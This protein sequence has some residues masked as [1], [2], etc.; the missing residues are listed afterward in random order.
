[1]TNDTLE[2]ISGTAVWALRDSTGNIIKDGRDAVTVPALSA[3]WLEEMDFHKTDVEH[4]YMSY[5]FEV[6][7]QVLSEGTVLFTAPKHFLFRNPNLRYEI[8]GDEI[9]IYADAYAR[10]VE[11]DSPDSDFIL[12]DN[13]FDMN[14]GSKTVK[15]LEGTPKTI[16]LRSVYDVR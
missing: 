7:G 10:Y 15:I 13:Y 6:N 4:T 9:T 16:A 5:A 2:E 3:V 11:I 14:A 12:S 8:N 1:V